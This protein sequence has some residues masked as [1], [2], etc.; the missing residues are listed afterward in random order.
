MLPAALGLHSGYGRAATGAVRSDRTVRF[1]TYATGLSSYDL[2]A[3]RL[4][5]GYT[6][7]Q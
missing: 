5:L 2:K 1:L 6:V 7:L 3:F 4:T